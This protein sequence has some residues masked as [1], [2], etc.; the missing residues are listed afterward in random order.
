MFNQRLNPSLLPILS[1]IHPV[2][3]NQNIPFTILSCKNITKY[4]Q[5]PTEECA[6]PFLPG[7][8]PYYP[9][10]HVI[11]GEPIG[12]G[13]GVHVLENHMSPFP[14]HGSAFNTRKRGIPIGPEQGTV[15]NKTQVFKGLSKEGLQTTSSLKASALVQLQNR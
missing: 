12:P 4:W 6:H 11:Q 15:D 10:L 1:Q 7:I 14:A 9:A 8:C 2:R 13:A 5:N 3:Y